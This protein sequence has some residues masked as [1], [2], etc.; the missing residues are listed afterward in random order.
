MNEALPILSATALSALA[1]AVERGVIVAPFGAMQI[2]RH[3]AK[4]EQADA[5][6]LLAALH[7]AGLE[8]GALATALRLAE[9]ARKA[10]DSKPQ[11][12]LVWSDLDI[13][14]SRDTAV[15]CNELFRRAHHSVVV[16][17]FNL[18]HKAKEGE[19]KGNP[20]LLPL[21]KRMAEI[22]GLTVRLFVNLRR[23]EY[24]A[25]ASERDVEDAFVGWFR[26]EIWPWEPVPEVYYDP[27]SLEAAGE[28]SACLH[29]KCVVVDDE[30]AFVTSANLTEAAQERN[31][32]AGVLLEDPAFA[33]SLRMQFESL[34]ERGFVRRMTRGME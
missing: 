10:G 14:G 4:A 6:R 29:A 28:E 16:S 22:S 2:G 13:A 5:L 33:R 27:R 31:I 7:A 24:M 20:V 34:I 11:P 8:G 32:E 21:A 17:T 25:H 1:S 15:V 19:A 9:A 26:K 12:V 30:R 18:G 3:I 23:L